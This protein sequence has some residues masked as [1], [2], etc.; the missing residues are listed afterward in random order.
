MRR[1]IQEKKKELTSEDIMNK[2][3]KSN[4]NKF[5]NKDE[6]LS[7]AYIIQMLFMGFV[8]IIVIIFVIFGCYLYIRH[9]RKTSFYSSDYYMKETA[10]FIGTNLGDSY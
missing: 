4:N 9:K 6:K 5:R 7:A 8:F 1:K 10:K 2:N 3:D